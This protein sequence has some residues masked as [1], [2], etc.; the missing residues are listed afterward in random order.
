MVRLPSTIRREAKQY[1]SRTT[2]MKS[3]TLCAVLLKAL[4]MLVSRHFV[5]K[6]NLF[7]RVTIVLPTSSQLSPTTAM[8]RVLVTR[9]TLS[10]WLSPRM[11]CRRSATRYSMRAT[12][13]SKTANLL[14]GRFGIVWITIPQNMLGLTLPTAKVLFTE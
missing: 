12:N 1:T 14:T 9:L 4:L 5:M 8:H 2:R 10:F 13:I 7:R 11:C 6:V 3:W